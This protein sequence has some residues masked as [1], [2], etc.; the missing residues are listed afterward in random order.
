MHIDYSQISSDRPA[1]QL[2]WVNP[3]TIALSVWKK[4]RLQNGQKKAPL[5]EMNPEK[6]S[7]YVVRS[8]L[9]LINVDIMHMKSH[10][11]SVGGKGYTGMSKPTYCRKYVLRLIAYCS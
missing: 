1:Q 6:L 10:V 2:A 11:F 4:E 7:R 5:R 3:T 9:W 8:H